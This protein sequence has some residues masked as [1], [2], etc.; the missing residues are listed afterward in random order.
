M[1]TDEQKKQLEECDCYR[2]RTNL[3]FFQAN[4]NICLDSQDERMF[5]VLGCL[6]FV[7]ANK[8]IDC[9]QLWEYLMSEIHENVRLNRA[10]EWVQD[11]V[12]RTRNE[13]VI[14]QVEYDTFVDL[15]AMDFD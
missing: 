8:H 14:L 2:C 5:E 6:C 4:P 12:E 10:V 1:L 13:L 9:L 15:S 11:E 7:Y 3:A